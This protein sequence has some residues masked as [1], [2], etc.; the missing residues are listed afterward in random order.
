MVVVLVVAACA[1]ACGSGPSAKRRPPASR[2]T[3]TTSTTVVVT[4]DGARRVEPRP[5]MADVHAIRFDGATPSA[6]GRTLVVRFTGGVAPCF[7]LDHVTLDETATRVTVTLFAGREPTPEPV[8]CIAIAALYE[9]DVHLAAPLD[10][11]AV[12]DG[13]S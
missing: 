7:V 8:A 10:G 11:R 1:S 5:G 13:A 4:P 12:D 2:P 3:S 9:T 6:D